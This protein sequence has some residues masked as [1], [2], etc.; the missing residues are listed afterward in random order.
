[1]SPFF[2]KE[3]EGCS[4]MLSFQYMIVFSVPIEVLFVVLVS[5]QTGQGGTFP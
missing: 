4:A 5:C 2:Q 1:V 3:V